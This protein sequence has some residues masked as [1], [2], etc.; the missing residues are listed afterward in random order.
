MKKVETEQTQPSLSITTDQLQLIQ[1][2][3]AVLNEV[4]GNIG[5]LEAKKVGLL[6]Y[7]E[8][9]NSEL[10]E[11]KSS[12]EKEYGNINIDISTGEYEVV[13]QDN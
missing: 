7:F 10:Q 4:L 1:K 12:L 2:Q 3:Q 6:R 5:Y 9:K 8:E 11:T 13:Q